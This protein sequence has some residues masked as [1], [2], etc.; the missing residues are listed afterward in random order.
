MIVILYIPTS[1]YSKQSHNQY[2]LP[3]LTSMTLNFAS[4]CPEM[5]RFSILIIAVYSILCMHYGWLYTATVEF[6]V[7]SIQVLR[8][9]LNLKI[10]FSNVIVCSYTINE[11]LLSTILK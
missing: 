4:Y 7:S 2:N 3:A 8:Q 6:K 10:N 5:R 11:D 9:Q 1:R